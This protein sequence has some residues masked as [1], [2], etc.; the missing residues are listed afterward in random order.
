ME[1]TEFTQEIMLF[2]EFAP[3]QLYRVLQLRS[4]VFVV[5]QTCYY[6]DMDGLDLLPETRHFLLLDGLNIVAYT[7]VL[8][9]GTSYSGYSS[10]GRIVSSPDYRGKG[11]GHQIVAESIKL[12]Q[13]LW[14]KYPIKI[15][16]QAH[17][18]EFYQQHGFKLIGEE[19]IEDGI[20]HVH[21]ERT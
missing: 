10:I 14:P 15:G 4:E 19:Y 7:R 16:A 21:M 12:C 1:N 18:T 3:K 2:N 9:P 20:P 17:L 6:Q 13:E 8:A 5:E 11:L